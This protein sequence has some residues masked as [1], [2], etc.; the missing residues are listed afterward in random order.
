M[1]GKSMIQYPKGV[2]F[3]VC[4]LGV[5]LMQFI[6]GC[7]E[8]ASRTCTGNSRNRS[9][10]WDESLPVTVSEPCP[11]DNLTYFG[12]R[13]HIVSQED[14]AKYYLVDIANGRM[15]QLRIYLLD[16]QEDMK[17]VHRWLVHNGQRLEE[18]SNVANLPQIFPWHNELLQY[19][20]N[21]NAVSYIAGYAEPDEYRK[22]VTIFRKCGRQVDTV[23]GRRPP[24]VKASEKQIPIEWCAVDQH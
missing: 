12:R 18:K 11:I 16:D 6:T 22:L 13:E 15:T 20:K 4:L 3:V 10:E 5:T 23:P 8:N 7:G 14:T 19:A 24:K 2:V 9:D 21:G 1:T 17:R